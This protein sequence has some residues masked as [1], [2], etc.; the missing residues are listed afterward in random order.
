MENIQMET[1]IVNRIQEGLTEKKTN[2]EEWREAE[3][4]EH[5]EVCL[6]SEDETVLEE[7]LHVIDDSLQKI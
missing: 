5:K 6:C 3:T 1:S 4:Q 7:H 2:L